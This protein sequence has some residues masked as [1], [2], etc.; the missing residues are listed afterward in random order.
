MSRPR[1]LSWNESNVREI[2]Q[3]YEAG[4]ISQI[5]LGRRYGVGQVH[6]GRIIYRQRWRHI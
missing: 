2:R 1:N 6:I 4:E 3:S 5:E